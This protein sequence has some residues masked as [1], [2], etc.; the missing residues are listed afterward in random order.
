MA[1]APPIFPL[2]M[3]LPDRHIC[4]GWIMQ[5]RNLMMKPLRELWPVD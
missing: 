4:H 5:A 2:Q 3:H 1:E